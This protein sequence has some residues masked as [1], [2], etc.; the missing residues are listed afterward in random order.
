MSVA[1]D[2]EPGTRCGYIYDG[3]NFVNVCVHHVI[4]A[5]GCP[6]IGMWESFSAMKDAFIRDVK[7][8]NAWCIGYDLKYHSQ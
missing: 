8:R 1:T 3:S 7:W 6:F 5:I 2:I 4:Y